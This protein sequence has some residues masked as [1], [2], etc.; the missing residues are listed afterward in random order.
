V[1][2]AGL[3][4]CSYTQLLP[5]GTVVVAGVAA[6]VG[7]AGIAVVERRGAVARMELAADMAVRRARLAS[8]VVQQPMRR[9]PLS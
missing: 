6:T 2:A 4:S 8:E 7:F 3:G 1:Q 5:A 9:T